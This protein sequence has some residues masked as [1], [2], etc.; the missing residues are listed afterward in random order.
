MK[1]LCDIIKKVR[2]D[3]PLSANEAKALVLE[4]E[5]LQQLA[6]ELESDLEILC[7]ENVH[8]NDFY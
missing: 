7:E 1:H 6:R 3:L 4:L 5:R 8:L 2:H